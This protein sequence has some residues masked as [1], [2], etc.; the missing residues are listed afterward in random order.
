[1]IALEIDGPE[2]TIGREEMT[3]ER[4]QPQLFRAWGRRAPDGGWPGG[5]W[6]G[7]VTHLRG[8]TVLDSRRVDARLP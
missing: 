7:T 3:L 2:G 1:M 4:D 5:A 6:S 8:G